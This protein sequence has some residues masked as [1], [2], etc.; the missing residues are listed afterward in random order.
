MN[1][2]IF[3][4]GKNPENKTSSIVFF[5]GRAHNTN[6]LVLIHQVCGH[7]SQGKLKKLKK[8]QLSN[9]QRNAQSNKNHDGPP[10]H[11]V[12]QGACCK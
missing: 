3:H 9:A 12:H 5:T 2:N 1:P 8:K 4:H 11:Q 6:T 10:T 7:A